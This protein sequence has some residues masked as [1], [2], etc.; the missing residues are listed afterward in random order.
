MARNSLEGRNGWSRMATNGLDSFQMA[1]NGLLPNGY[2][3]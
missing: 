2:I 1:K 3:S